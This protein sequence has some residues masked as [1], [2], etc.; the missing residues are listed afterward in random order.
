MRSVQEPT[1]RSWRVADGT[2]LVYRLFDV[3]DA[4]DLSRAEALV[5][6]PRS[7]LKLEGAQTHTALDI[8][9]PPLYVAL[10]RREVPLKAGPRPA[11]ASARLFDYG[12]VSV[13][14][15]LAIPPGTE[16]ADL[17]P[18]AEE[19]SA[20]ATPAIDQAARTEAE[21][22]ARA[23]AP[24]LERP[25]RW[26]GLETYQIFFVR[27]L[28]QPASAEEVLAGAPIA[29]LLL[30]E[31]SE[32]SLSRDERNDVLGHA[33][34][35]LADDLAVVDWNSAFLLEP[36][37]VGDIPDLLEFA[38]AH[39]LE[40]RYYD[41][42]LDRELHTIYDEL[43]ATRGISDLF[44]LRHARLQRR[45]A[46]LL[47]ELSEMTERLEN[48]IKIV[49]DFYLARLYQSSVRRF[50]L[51]ARQ[52][53]VLRKE[54]LLSGVNELMK[55]TADRRRSELLELTVILLITWEV[56]YA[57]FRHG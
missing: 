38:T 8:P 26:E 9:R 44:T 3:A 56:L 47:L 50:R 24:A 41:A 49:G 17:V 5:S 32:V 34:S 53:S 10:G 37:G 15:R 57:L 27:G 42:L 19:L 46:A 6:A 14:Y 28:E 11:E 7:R 29:E 40:L 39:L 30:G 52:E 48:A 21:E 16:L 12:V 1:R 18:L 45:T 25:H 35:Y 36:S 20:Q 2:L 13:V 33:Y 51:P 55:G 22:L 31:T 43:D 54:R 4:L 23:L